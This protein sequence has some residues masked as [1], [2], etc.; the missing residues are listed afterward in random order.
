M[1]ELKF[2][3]WLGDRAATEE[4]LERIEEIEVT[5]EMDALWEARLRIGMCLDERGSWR[6]RPDEMARRF[7]ASAS[8]STSGS[9][10]FMPLIDGPVASFEN[11]L[12]S[13]PGRST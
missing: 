4:E 11:S 12:D 9:G 13:Q 6:H 1:G 3:V 8:N 7:R 2:R 10:R 5:Q